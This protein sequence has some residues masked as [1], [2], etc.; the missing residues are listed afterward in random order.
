[1]RPKFTPKKIVNK[2]VI[3]NNIKINNNIPIYYV[4]KNKEPDFNNPFFAIDYVENKRIWLIYYVN[5]DNTISSQIDDI[6]GN[7][8]RY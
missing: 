5:M 4:W 1:M 2:F 6:T 7:V 3:Y 8:C